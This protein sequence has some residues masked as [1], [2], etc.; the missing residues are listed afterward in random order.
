MEILKEPITESCLGCDRVTQDGEK[1][2][3]KSYVVP[4]SMWRNRNCLMAS[5]LKREAIEEKK[6]NPLKKSKRS[7][8]K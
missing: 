6:V 7:M 5:H 3:C 1:Q 4:K 2:I 8:G